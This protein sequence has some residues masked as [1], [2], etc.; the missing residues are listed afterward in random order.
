MCL[1]FSSKQKTTITYVCTNIL[2]IKIS[3][4]DKGLFKLTFIKINVVKWLQGLK[5]CKIC[6][7]KP[8]K[9]FC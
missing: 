6:Q 8:K 7:I 1:A 4:E 2:Q 3:S 5:S 9:A